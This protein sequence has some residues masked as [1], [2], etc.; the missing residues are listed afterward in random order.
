SPGDCATGARSWPSWAGTGQSFPTSTDCSPCRSGTCS[1]RTSRTSASTCCGCRRSWGSGPVVGA[2]ADSNSSSASGASPSGTS[3]FPPSGSRLE[4]AMD[5]RHCLAALL[6]LSCASGP[7]TFRDEPVVWT[8]EGDKRPF[9]PRPEYF[10]S[11]LAWTGAE[12]TIFRPV[13]DALTLKLKG[14]SVDVNAVDEVPD[15]SWFE[16]RLSRRQLSTEEMVRGSCNAPP[17]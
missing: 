13:S 8:G 1:A 9:A 5:R 17:P 12:E 14:E 4:S 6:A 7:R 11:P 16:N 2:S 10:G 3:A 15:S